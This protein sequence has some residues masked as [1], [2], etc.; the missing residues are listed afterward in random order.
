MNIKIK[1]PYGFKPFGGI[2]VQKKECLLFHFNSIDNPLTISKKHLF[3]S[4]NQDIEAQSLKVGDQLFHE[5]LGPTTI[6]MIEDIGIQEVYDIVGVEHESHEYLGSG[7]IHH[8]CSFS[9]STKTLVDSTALKAQKIKTPARIAMNE[10]FNIYK[11]PEKDYKYVVGCDVGEGTGNDYSVVQVGKILSKT[12]VEQVATYR[13]NTIS[14]R[15]FAMVIDEIAVYYNDAMIMLEN[16]NSGHVT[17]SELWHHVDND[18]LI[19]STIGKR[20]ELGIR[21]T[22]KSKREANLNIKDY[23]EKGWLKIYDETTIYELSK[24]TEIRPGIFQN[25][26]GISHDDCV[27]SLMWM[28]YFFLM[29]DFDESELIEHN[30]EH[31]LELGLLGS[32]SNE[33]I[34]ELEESI[35]CM[36]GDDVSNNQLFSGFSYNDFVQEQNEMHSDI[37]KWMNDQ[38]NNNRGPNSWF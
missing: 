32:L 19:N 15:D 26:D 31:N 21:S 11:E 33:E 30:K 14:A 16:N 18:H 6:S 20:K 3:R 24:Y 25:G 9:G 29:P 37:F 5:S 17:A 12:Y 13:C 28:L 7:F 36:N 34:N 10:C 1:T 2:R 38:Q 27:T 35:I 23:I 8:N 4:N 22:K